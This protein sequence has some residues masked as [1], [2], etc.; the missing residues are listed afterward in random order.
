MRNNKGFIGILF[1]LIAVA[2]MAIVIVRTDLFSGG[3]SD[4]SMIENGLDAV[5]KAEEA[6]NLLEQKSQPLPD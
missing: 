6:K 3:K 4:K 5:D 1:L 2:V